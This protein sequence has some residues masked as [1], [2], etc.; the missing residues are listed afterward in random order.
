MY[1][2]ENGFNAAS[3]GL[4][5]GAVEGCQPST[6]SLSFLTPSDNGACCVLATGLLLQTHSQGHAEG[7]QQ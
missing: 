4:Y 2:Q 5:R 3:Q 7:R 6:L 1:I